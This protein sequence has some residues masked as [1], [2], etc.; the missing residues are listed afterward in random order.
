MLPIVVTMLVIVVLAVLVV[1]YVAFPHRGREIP[2]ASWLSN[3][4]TKTVDKVAPDRADS[5]ASEP[6]PTRG[7]QAGSNSV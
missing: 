5:K 1:A 4:M 2:Q 7:A 3:A 6:D